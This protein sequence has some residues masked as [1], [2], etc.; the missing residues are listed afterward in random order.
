MHDRAATPIGAV[1]SA[2]A[3]AIEIIILLNIS[4]RITQVRPR[5]EEKRSP[6][7]VGIAQRAVPTIEPR[8]FVCFSPGILQGKWLH[9]F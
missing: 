7:M 8:V 4:F 6:E 2:A 3:I 5:V 9:F 1:K